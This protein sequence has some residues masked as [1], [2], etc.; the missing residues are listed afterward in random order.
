MFL[1]FQQLAELTGYKQ[2]AALRRWLRRNRI[3]FTE[4]K[5]G[6]V[7]V[8]SALD[9]GILGATKTTPDFSEFNEAPAQMPRKTRRDILRPSQ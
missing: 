4:G 3:P 7:T 1:T 6:P 5:H 9:R 8:Q 2:K